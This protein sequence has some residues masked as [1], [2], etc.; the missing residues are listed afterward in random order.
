[1]VIASRVDDTLCTGFGS[2]GVSD[3]ERYERFG[4]HIRGSIDTRV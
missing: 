4:H 1:M 3:V 2:L